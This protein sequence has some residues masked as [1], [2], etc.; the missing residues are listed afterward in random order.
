MFLVFLIIGVPSLAARAAESPTSSFLNEV[1]PILSR[2]GCNLGTCHGNQQ[3]K[4]GFK[5]SLRGQHPARD[6]LTLARELGGRRVN[7]LRPESSL[8][9]QKPLAEIPHQGGKRFDTDS[10]AYQ[11]I[12]RWI[13]DGL[14]M[15]S[16]D[17]PRL[18]DLQVTPR[19][20]TVY[21]PQQ[22]V[23]IQAIATFSDGSKK[24]VTHLS[25]FEPSSLHVTVSPQGLATSERAGSSLVN[26]RFLD[27][28]LPVRLEFVPLRKDFTWS[29]PEPDN[30]IDEAVFATLRRTRIQPS[31]VCDD[32]TFVRRA[33]LDFTGLLPSSQ[34]AREFMAST[35]I[36]KRTKL[37]D[38]L[39]DS[40]EFND[41]QAL[42]WADLLRVEEKTLDPKASKFFMA[43]FVNVSKI[44]NHSI[45]L[46]Q[47]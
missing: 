23:Q 19:L 5:L 45:S 43:G 3:G 41:F 34:K 9:L 10:K 4:G 46:R 21:A 24:N 33:F 32:S 27:R 20:K 7:R 2:S 25:V 30:F 16:V 22:S 1:M 12:H 11:I 28:Q 15:D 36:D 44:A 6:Y 42:R 26:V 29:A 47:N 8:L 31:V 18:I 37:I 35:D 40:P 39:L 38:E 13:V 17:A 14:P